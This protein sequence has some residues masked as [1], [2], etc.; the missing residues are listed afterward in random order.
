[1]PI[2]F[3]A[4]FEQDLP[5]SVVLQYPQLYMDGQKDR[6]LNFRRFGMW[7]FFGLWDSV[8]ATFGVFP[9]AFGLSQSMNIDGLNTDQRT[10]SVITYTVLVLAGSIHLWIHTRLWIL[11]IHLSYFLSVIAWFILAP[12]YSTQLCIILNSATFYGVAQILYKTPLT[13][14]TVI[15]LVWVCL[16]PDLLIHFVLRLEKPREAMIF[17]ED[18]S[19]KEWRSAHRQQN[20]TWCCVREDCGKCQRCCCCFPSFQIEEIS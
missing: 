11:P 7:F 19:T 2:V 14:L 16:I 20:S 4:L 10:A 15:V 1:M 18:C 12:L 9:T 13:Y 17:Q 3:Y 8:V 5:A 6:F